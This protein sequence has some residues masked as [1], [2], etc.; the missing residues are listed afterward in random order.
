MVCQE[1]HRSLS[2]GQQSLK[3]FKELYNR[4][5]PSKRET[6]LDQ[7]HSVITREDLVTIAVDSDTVVGA[8]KR[9]KLGKSDG[10]SL[11]SDHVLR[12]PPLLASKL[13][14]LLIYCPASS[15]LHS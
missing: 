3:R 7:L 1:I 5:D 9:L 14:R 11:M 10:R 8:L 4:C 12:A 15:W 2:Y 6:L 13:S